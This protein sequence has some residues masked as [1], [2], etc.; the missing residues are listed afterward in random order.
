MKKTTM[1]MTKTMKMMKTT[2]R[3]RNVKTK[4]KR[5][6]KKIKISSRT[7]RLSRS[8]RRK[9]SRRMSRRATSSN[10][11]KARRKTKRNRSK[12]KI[13]RMKDV[14]HS[15]ISLTFHSMKEKTFNLQRRSVRSSIRRRWNQNFCSIFVEVRVCRLIYSKRVSNR[16]LMKTLIRLKKKNDRS[17]AKTTLTRRQNVVF[18]SIFNRFCMIIFKW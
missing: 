3:K 8:R 1:K 2:K 10:R 13:M 14:F 17:R 5:I 6:S 18:V 12:A 16:F 11:I 9:S 7:N 4:M 15:I